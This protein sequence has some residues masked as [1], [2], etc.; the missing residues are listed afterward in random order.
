MALKKLKQHSAKKF[1]VI[2]LSA[3]VALGIAGCDDMTRGERTAAGAAVGAVVG[4]VVGH[5]VDD[6]KGRYVGAVVGAIA[7]GAV[8]RYM[9]TQQNEFEQL[10]KDEQA[11]GDL[12]IVRIADD[13][14]LIG[15]ASNASFDTASAQI[16]PVAT[17]TYG[18]IADVLK[19]YPKT[20]VHVIGHTDSRGTDEYNMD[21]SQRRAN[22]VTQFMT[23]ASISPNRLIS[24]G[25]GETEP[26]ATNETEAGRAANRRVDIIVRAI[27][28]GDENKASQRQNYNY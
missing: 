22:S 23:N 5:Q 9:D 25:R 26:R 7:G 3:T 8:G 4:A 10:L 20:I 2:G 24:Q 13:A 15:L 28:E 27:V 17:N 14:V 1:A 16:K 6:D 11:R 19:K 21:L 18:K 12:Q